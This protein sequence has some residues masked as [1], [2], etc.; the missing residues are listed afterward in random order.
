MA[1]D[2]TDGIRVDLTGGTDQADLATKYNSALGM[3][4]GVQRITFGT[5]TTFKD[6]SDTVG[7]GS[8][9]LPVALYTTAGAAIQSI[10]IAADEQFVAGSDVQPL[11]AVRRDLPSSAELSGDGDIA[12]FP[13]DRH[14]RVRVGGGPRHINC[15]VNQVTILETGTGNGDIGDYL[16][17]IV[18][19][20]QSL[21]PDTATALEILDDTTVLL[22]FKGGTDIY[23]SLQP[24]VVPIGAYST[25][26]AWS[27]D[28]G[29]NMRVFA[30]GMWA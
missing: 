14:G 20:P 6:V 2:T 19:Q 15:P 27:I 23:T 30:V 25:V 28:C 7:A 11:G 5:G 12:P 3:H 24:F 1:I 29:T 21:T 9:P 22:S 4:Y 10:A 17:Y 18:C 26:G 8:G 13:V 16:D